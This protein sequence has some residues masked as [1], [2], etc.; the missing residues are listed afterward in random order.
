MANDAT[1][2]VDE[3]EYLVDTSKTWIG[4]RLRIN[5]GYS[6]TLDSLTIPMGADDALAVGAALI[7]YSD[8]VAGRP[9]RDWSAL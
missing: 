7:A 1:L 5:D 4:L 9:V 2:K 3:F 8:Y 6:H